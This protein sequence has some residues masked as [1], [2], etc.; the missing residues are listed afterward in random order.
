MSA[1]EPTTALGLQSRTLPAPL[2]TGLRRA[3]DLTVAL[4]VLV[5]LAPVL[6]LAALLVRL[7]TPGSPFF[8]QRRLGRDGV[9]FTVNKFRTMHADA[10]QTPH[11]EFIAQLMTAPQEPGAADDALFKLAGDARVTRVGRLLRRTSIDELPQLIN[12][13][14]GEMSL[15]GPR[16]AI[17]YELEHYQPWFRERFAVKPGLTGLWQVSGRNRRTFEEMIRLDVEYARRQSL[18]LDLS[19]LARTPWA[20]LTSRGVA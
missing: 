5:V 14:R 13:V 6:L 7:E 18:L 2:S 9:P 3:L 4:I 19:I 20:V 12:V 17:P 10:D 8:R 15:V 11:R 16:P 1:D